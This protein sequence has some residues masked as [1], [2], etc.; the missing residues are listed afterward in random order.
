[1][2][3]LPTLAIG[4]AL[5]YNLV[6]LNEA[7]P[8]AA[9]ITL[10]ATLLGFYAITAY[11]Y[12]MR[13]RWLQTITGYTRQGVALIVGG[14]SERVYSVGYSSVMKIIEKVI[15]DSMVFWTNWAVRNT[16][17]QRSEAETD[18]RM[19][20]E[21]VILALEEKVIHAISSS[22]PMPDG[23]AEYVLGIHYLNQMAVVWDGERVRTVVDMSKVLRHEVGHHCLEALG[24]YGGN[25]GENHHA[26]YDKTKYEA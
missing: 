2:V 16:S 17:K 12:W 5:H 10:S 4:K 13:H 9:W 25:T 23:F 20:F 7:L 22:G 18:L 6:V 8:P 15:D 26:I 1:M 21:G 3:L 24:V 19:S 14:V 11:R